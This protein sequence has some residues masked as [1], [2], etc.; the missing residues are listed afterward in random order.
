[1]ETLTEARSLICSGYDIVC[2]RIMDYTVVV[3][4]PGD[5][6]KSEMS[7]CAGLVCD[8]G[9]VDQKKVASNLPRARVLAVVRNAKTIVGLGAIKRVMRRHTSD[10]AKSSGY[11]LDPAMSEIGYIA[12]HPEHRRK[13]LSG[14]IL[15]ALLQQRPGALFATTD[16]YAMKRTLACGQF[17]LRGH[18]WD[19]NRGKLSLWVK[20]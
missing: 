15:G 7:Q 16:D 17:V 8:G 14:R 18:E 12:V 10:V 2:S 19:G 6:S 20:T 11:A 3:C 9:A 5:L 13:G 4:V 1:M